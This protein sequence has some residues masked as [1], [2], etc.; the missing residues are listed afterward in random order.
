MKIR[1]LITGMACIGIWTLASG[2]AGVYRAT[3]AAGTVIQANMDKNDYE[4]LG[5]TEGKSTITSIL[6]GLVAVIDGD[7]YRVLGIKFFEDQYAFADHSRLFVHADDRAY[8]KAL[9]QTPDA[10]VVARKSVL[11]TKSGFPCIYTTKEVT[12]QGKALKF[13]AHN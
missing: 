3:P 2:C 1:L 6:F 5:T 8:Y 9:A 12:F 4:V 7:K 10:D 13:K 11:E